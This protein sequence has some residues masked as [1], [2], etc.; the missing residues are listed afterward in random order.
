MASLTLSIDP[1]K[2]EICAI[3]VA[4]L[5]RNELQVTPAQA[6]QRALKSHAPNSVSVWYSS[7]REKA[8]TKLR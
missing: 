7:R 8:A 4:Q 5:H 1:V 6:K 3:R 2:D